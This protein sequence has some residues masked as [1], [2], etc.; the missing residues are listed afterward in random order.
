MSGGSFNYLFRK[1]A[2]ELLGRLSDLEE[3]ADVLARLG[4]APDAAE[5]T[6]TLLLDSR[7]FLNRTNPVLERLNEVWQA[8][9]WWQSCDSSEEKVRE[10]LQTYR[11]VS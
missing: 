9:E 8:V 5:E 3:M 1:D 2:A 7:A 10:A 11:D 6:Q 4:Y